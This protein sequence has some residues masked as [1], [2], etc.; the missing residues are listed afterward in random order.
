ML[1]R[2][3]NR[4]NDCAELCLSDFLNSN[5]ELLNYVKKGQKQT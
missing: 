3:Q 4:L 1:K 2:G 5:D